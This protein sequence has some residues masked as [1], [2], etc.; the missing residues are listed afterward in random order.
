MSTEYATRFEAPDRNKN[1]KLKTAVGP[2][3]ISG[4]TSNKE[5][6]DV[7]TE[8]PG[9]RW[10][11]NNGRTGNSDYKDKFVPYVYPKVRDKKKSIINTYFSLNKNRCSLIVMLD[12]CRKHF[13]SQCLK[14]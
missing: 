12:Q 13:S 5:K 3:E 10:L 2:K 7:L 6:E 1:V 11:Y 8:T 14:Y 9:E 4:F